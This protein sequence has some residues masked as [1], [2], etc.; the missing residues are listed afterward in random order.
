MSFS[1]LKITTLYSEFLGLYY[2]KYPHITG[3]SYKVQ[4]DHLLSSTS[5]PVGSYTFMLR[6]LGVDANAL[7]MNSKPLLKRWEKENNVRSNGSLI[8]RIIRQI[9]DI[10]PVIIWLDDLSLMNDRV[11]KTIRQSVP[12]VRLIFGSHCA[13]FSRYAAENFKSLDFIITCTPGLTNEFRSYGIRSY[14][15]YHGFDTSIHQLISPVAFPR[16]NELIF[17]GSLYQGGRFHK[18]RLEYIEHLLDNFDIRLFCNLESR[19]KTF[20]KKVLHRMF[21]PVT[22]LTTKQSLSK[23]PFIRRYNEFLY[24]P[25]TDYSRQLRNKNKNPVFGHEMFRLLSE[26]EIVFNIH[27]E[28]AGD[29]AG[30][31]RL[32]EAT[33]MGCCLIT[34]FKQNMNELFE[35]DKEVI[36]YKTVDECIE[37]IKWLMT[38]KKECE[39]IAGA[40]QKRTLAD[41]T[42]QRR[43]TELIKILSNELNTTVLN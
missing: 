14:L 13:P 11:I 21:K 42:V 27:G 32:F 8:R 5:E 28:V 22:K 31:V 20:M 38:N 9:A 35:V 29:Y 33:G 25:V 18:T 2:K 4:S 40:G 17:T 7:I 41:H 43:C 30:N 19:S 34:D 36:V 24:T 23:M 6:D 39:A 15:L 16:P 12:S 37:K 10:K 26:S 3:E 1:L